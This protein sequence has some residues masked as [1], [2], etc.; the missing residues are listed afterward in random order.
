LQLG[1]ERALGDVVTGEAPGVGV[2]YRQRD[3]L[4][5][6]PDVGVPVEREEL[7]LAGNRDGRELPDLALQ[8]HLGRGIRIGR[9]AGE[10]SLEI[11]DIRREVRLDELVGKVHLAGLDAHLANADRPAGLDEDL[12]RWRPGRRLL[13]LLLARAP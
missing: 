8:I 1:G 13:G 10:R 4:E 6:H 7:N 11:L 12:A 9:Q 2:E 5:L 3:V